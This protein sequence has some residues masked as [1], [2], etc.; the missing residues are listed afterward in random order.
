MDRLSALWRFLGRIWDF[1][2]DVPW[3]I[4]GST[5]ESGFGILLAAYTG[6]AT[7]AFIISSF[8]LTREWQHA[9][10]VGFSEAKSE[11]INKELPEE[12]QQKISWV[13]V[14]QQQVLS[15]RF[16]IPL[17]LMALASLYAWVA[18]SFTGVTYATIG[19]LWLLAGLTVLRPWWVATAV[20]AARKLHAHG[21]R[22]AHLGDLY[23]MTARGAFGH[24]MR[25]GL[26][27]RKSSSPRRR[28]VGY[29]KVLNPIVGLFY[30]R[31]LKLRLIEPL[32]WWFAVGVSW[33]ISMVVVIS[34]MG[35]DLWRKKDKLQPAWAYKRMD[36]PTYVG[37]KLKPKARVETVEAEAIA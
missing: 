13:L 29:L 20:W 5:L 4:F 25:W 37:K 23:V 34:K 6:V 21:V 32:L 33:P 1:V 14:R 26:L 8:A 36:E 15:L 31:W 10:D 30:L 2:I 16:I 24:Y 27:D 3:L 9:L 7:L 35:Y 17:G 28:F 12:A 22:E 18:F 11:K 19:V